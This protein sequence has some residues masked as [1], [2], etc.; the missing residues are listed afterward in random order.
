M[1]VPYGWAAEFDKWPQHE[2]DLE[3]LVA[4][5]A[6]EWNCPVVGTD[7]VGVITH[8]PWT[9]QT[10]GGAS[11]VADASGQTVTVLRDRDVEVRVVEVAITRHN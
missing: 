4:R 1:L 6:K 9:G 10:Y 5:R 11:V 3:H 8:G 7:L 2:K